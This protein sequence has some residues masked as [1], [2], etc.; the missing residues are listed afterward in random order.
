MASWEGSQA[1]LKEWYP[2]HPRHGHAA[3]QSQERLAMSKWNIHMVPAIV[4]GFYC[5]S[6]S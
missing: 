3:A 1:E 2:P 6:C 5:I 4:F